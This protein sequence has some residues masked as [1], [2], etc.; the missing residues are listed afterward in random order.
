M[1][2]EDE[3]YLPGAWISTRYVLERGQKSCPYF[4]AFSHVNLAVL[5]C[6]NE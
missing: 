2:D 3:K 6:G 1:L 5:S 4:F